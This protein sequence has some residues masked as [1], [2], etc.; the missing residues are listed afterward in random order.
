[1]TIGA[2]VGVLLLPSASPTLGY[3]IGSLIVGF[4]FVFPFSAIVLAVKAARSKRGPRSVNL[5]PLF[6]VWVSTLAIMVTKGSSVASSGLLLHATA[7]TLIISNALLF[8]LAF[9]VLLAKYVAT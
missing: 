9:S 5:I 1:M 3:L 4:V 7:L 8:P 6:L 2:A